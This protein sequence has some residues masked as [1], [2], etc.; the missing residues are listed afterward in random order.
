MREAGGVGAGVEHLEAATTEA[1]RVGQAASRAG[2]DWAAAARAVAR[3]TAR[4]RAVRD[5]RFR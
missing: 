2:V 1:N 5:L 3:E 4:N